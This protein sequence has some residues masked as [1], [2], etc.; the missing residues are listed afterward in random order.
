MDLINLLKKNLIK[1]G[2]VFTV[3]IAII[4][5]AAIFLGDKVHVSGSD[6]YTVIEEKMVRSAKKYASENTNVLPEM[7]KEKKLK[8]DTLIINKYINDIK[9]KK[10]GKACS[11][12]VTIIKEDSEKYTYK[13]YLDCDKEYTTTKI[14]DK[15]INDGLKSSGDGLYEINSKY[16]FKGEKPN[17][18]I[19]IDKIMYR[20]LSINDE[21]ELRLISTVLPE[22]FT[23]WDD[24]YNSLE[25]G[26]YGINDFNRSRLKVYLDDYYKS[27]AFPKGIKKYIEAKPLCIGK[28]SNSDDANLTDE[29]ECAALSDTLPIGILQLNE[30]YNASLDENCKTI[31]ERACMNYNYLVEVNQDAVT[32]TAAKENTSEIYTVYYG[33]ARREYAYKSF[34][35]NITFYINKEALYQKGD[36]TEKNPYKIRMFKNQ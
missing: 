2:I 1:I 18:Y 32:I 35:P 25:N 14:A 23:T 34:R 27:D 9:A 13:P 12:Y 22:T 16:V 17:N 33:K 30:F 28:R 11:G 5:A 29:V 15:I 3:L 8:L 26:S 10:S 36:G 6:S 20:I 4:V 19:E 7:N 31:Q 24:R 21:G